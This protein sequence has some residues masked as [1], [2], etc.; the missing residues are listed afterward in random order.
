[1]RFCGLILLVTGL[2][3]SVCV[4]QSEFETNA[5]QHFP[6]HANTIALIRM[7]AIEQSLAKQNPEWDAAQALE[8]VEQLTG[9]PGW[10]DELMI[11]SLL[12]PA[13]AEEVWAAGLVLHNT[14]QSLKQ[15]ADEN[16]GTISDVAGYKSYVT[17]T[18]TLLIELRK[19][20]MAGYRPNDR[21]QA[22]AWIRDQKDH[23]HTQLKPYLTNAINSKADIILSLSLQDMLDAKHV[24]AQL[25]QDSRF[26]KYKQLIDDLIPLLVGIKGVQLEITLG[27]QTEFQIS[28]DFEQEVGTSSAIVKALFQG[29]LDDIGANIP[30]FEK[31]RI[32][33]SGNSLKLQGSLS[34]HSLL[35]VISAVVPPKVP[36]AQTTVATA[37]ESERQAQSEENQKRIQL[38]ASQRY[39]Q[40]IEQMVDNLKRTRINV[41][42]Y[43]KTITWHQ[44]FATRI[45]RLS[46]TNVPDEMVEL[47]NDIAQ[48]FNALARSLQG[49]ALQIDT[50]NRAVVYN[51]DYT[52]PAWYANY[53]GGAGYRPGKLKVTSNLKEI[54]AQQAE[55][56]SQGTDDRLKIWDMIDQD[57]LEMQK[58]LEQ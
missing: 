34:E 30:E 36:I 20:V 27:T 46:T 24:E 19:Q 53:W 1:M 3:S 4:A 18:G 35:R 11:A 48:K 42:E 28:I 32:V 31:A 15:L 43:N 47:G 39:L 21:Q 17:S 57:L 10:V 7:E 13:Q 37:T 50:T 55:M 54:R 52:P 23:Q 22:T 2:S 12:R 56:V 14:N 41:P 40:K 45:Q 44:N 38:R 6:R 33:P 5:I 58:M 49:Q 16:D 25:Q 9:I 51:T 29:M 26:S 8:A